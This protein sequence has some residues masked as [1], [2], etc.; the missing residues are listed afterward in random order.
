M[1]QKILKSLI[2]FD[3]SDGQGLE[4]REREREYMRQELGERE[5]ERAPEERVSVQQYHQEADVICNNTIQQQTENEIK[6][7]NV[8]VESERERD[9]HR[10]LK[11]RRP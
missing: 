6:K 8:R 2:N 5:R 10:A 9:L 7:K 11:E 4:S 1:Q 3:Q